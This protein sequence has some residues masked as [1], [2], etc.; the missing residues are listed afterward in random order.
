MK[1]GTKF[2]IKEQNGKKYMVE[3]SRPMSRPINTKHPKYNWPFKDE[4]K[5]K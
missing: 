2:K 3:H 4:K 1:E 5:K